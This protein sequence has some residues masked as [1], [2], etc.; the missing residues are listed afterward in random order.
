MLFPPQRPHFAAALRDVTARAPRSRALA[1]ASLGE[2]PEGSEEAAVEALL[3]LADDADATV[4][5][6]AIASLGRLGDERALEVV[7]GR[8]DDGDP[9]VRQ[10]ALI[11]A[12][13]L[14]DDRA[15]PALTR[16]L[17]H[18]RPDMRFQALASLAVLAPDQAAAPLAKLAG[19]PDEEVRAHLAD[20]LGSLERRE[21]GPTLAQL[22]DDGS[23]SVRRAAAI[24]LARIGDDRGAAALIEALDDKERV[25]E[26]AWALGELRV[27]G[28]REPL[29][30]VAQSVLKPLATKAAAAAALVRLGDRR[31]VP[32]LRAVL[33][34]F[35]SDARSYAVE[36]VGE[37]GLAVLADDVAALAKRP[38]GADPVVVAKT[39]GKLAAESPR[40]REALVAMAIRD[41]EAGQAAREALG[42]VQ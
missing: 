18:E 30:K 4:R 19:D 40:A 20:V 5:G 3:I 31:G 42:D 22:L 37:L 29:F 33:R 24:A 16:A 9:M 38:R 15:I 26:A 14:G 32:L 27:E 39:L 2:P 17:R 34:A 10:I 11:A 8:F 1:A 12:A 6:A 7:L 36:L 35:R 25:F 23:I 28:A 13:D 41:D 21:A